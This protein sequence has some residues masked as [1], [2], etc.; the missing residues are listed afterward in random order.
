VPS[1]TA[2]SPLPRSKLTPLSDG[3]EDAPKCHSS[4]SGLPDIVSVLVPMG[5]LE[6]ENYVT[7]QQTACYLVRCASAI[8][9]GKEVD[10]P[11]SYFTVGFK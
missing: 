6:G 1:L 4:L 2:T 3:A 11:L 8:R 7:Y 10:A 5:T 9:N